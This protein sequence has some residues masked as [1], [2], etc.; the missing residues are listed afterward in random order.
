MAM[1]GMT[2]AAPTLTATDP[3]QRVL[4]FIDMFLTSLVSTTTLR[5]RLQAG[6]KI[7]SPSPAVFAQLAW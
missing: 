3:P 4:S 5:D 6:V 2:S 1:I 7:A